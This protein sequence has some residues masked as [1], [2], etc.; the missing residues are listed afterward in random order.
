LEAGVDPA[1]HQHVPRASLT[2][3]RTQPETDGF[4]Y[5]GRTRICS[6]MVRNLN[7]ARPTSQQ[8]ATVSGILPSAPTVHRAPIGQLWRLRHWSLDSR[9]PQP[10]RSFA[11]L[12]TLATNVAMQSLLKIALRTP[13]RVQIRSLHSSS[14]TQALPI[15]LPRDS[16]QPVSCSR[17]GVQDSK[18]CQYCAASEVASSL[19]RLT[20]SSYPSA[21]TCIVCAGHRTLCS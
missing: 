12:C 16:P 10:M 15:M 20:Y 17:L 6:P 19:A 7:P 8:Y 4:N 5:P 11:R 18:R 21:M 3:R 14:D 1:W 2:K 13:A 9:R